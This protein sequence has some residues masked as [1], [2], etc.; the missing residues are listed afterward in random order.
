MYVT[1]NNP[2]CPILSLFTFV[3]SVCVSVCVRVHE[4]ASHILQSF[5]SYYEYFLMCGGNDGVKT[6]FSP[7]SAF[8]T[9]P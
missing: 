9:K 3:V 1:T 6:Q 2:E 5:I 4:S 8:P 7:A